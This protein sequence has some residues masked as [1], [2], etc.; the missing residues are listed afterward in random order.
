[1]KRRGLTVLELLVGLT[2]LML[3]ATFVSQL[4]YVVLMDRR[5]QEARAMS[6]YLA[7]NV[8]EAAIASDAAELTEAWAQSQSSLAAVKDRWPEATRTVQLKVHESGLQEIVVS[9]QMRPKEPVYELHGWRA[10]RK[11][12]GAP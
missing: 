1:M 7:N 6:Q 4:Y 10:L 5:Q 11:S 3:A 9:V 2:S 8:L 12:M